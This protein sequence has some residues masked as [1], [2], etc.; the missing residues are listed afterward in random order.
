MRCGEP[1]FKGL[2]C[3]K[4]HAKV[5]QRNADGLVRL[6]ARRRAEIDALKDKPCADCGGSFHPFVMDFDHREGTEKK[7][8]VAAAIPLG[9]S[10]ESV[11]A[12]AAKCDVVCSNCHRMRTWRRMEDQRRRV[13]PARAALRDSTH[14]PKGHPMSG[15]NTK[16]RVRS[17]GIRT[18][19]EYGCIQCIRE[20]DRARKPRKHAVP[21]IPGFDD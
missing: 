4:H 13:E 19:D 16:V 12:E 17:L 3:E 15:E 20:A 7:F 21:V 2:L 18:R 6:R 11:K 14:C 5:R 1:R 9:L 8:N 10:I